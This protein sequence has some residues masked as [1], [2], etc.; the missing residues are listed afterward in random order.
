MK[1]EITDVKITIASIVPS[2]SES[3][4]LYDELNGHYQVKVNIGV[5]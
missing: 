1:V 3:V 5:T 2:S 4:L